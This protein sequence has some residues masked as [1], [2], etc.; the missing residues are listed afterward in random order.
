VQQ[1]RQVARG[2]LEGEHG[3]RVAELLRA[4][5]PVLLDLGAGVALDDDWIDV[6]QA[7]SDDPPA[8]ALL[9]RPDGYV[10]WA[11]A[12]GIPEAVS[13]WFR[14]DRLPAP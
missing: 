5:R 12:P 7:R 11:G 4:G 2:L 8:D 14:P 13:A 6:V 3:R 10:A 1:R 9:I